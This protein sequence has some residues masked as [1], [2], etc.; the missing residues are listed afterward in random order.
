MCNLAECA[1]FVFAFIVFSRNADGNKGSRGPAVIAFDAQQV[2]GRL[3]RNPST[4]FL[5]YSPDGRLHAVWTE[6]H[7]SPSS[8]QATARARQHHGMG[9]RGPSPMRDALLASSR[10][11]GK[12]WS[13]PKRIND[14]V[15]AVQAKRT[16]RKSPLDWK[17]EFTPFGQFPALRGTRL[18]PTSAFQRRTAKAASRQREP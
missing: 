10:V 4:P 18:A 14:A 3:D 2:L 5:R 17:I 8:F 7:D 12:S 13:M 16:G 15:E 1:I 6:D 9:H 11:G